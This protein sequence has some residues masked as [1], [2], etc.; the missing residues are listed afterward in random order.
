MKL[1]TL[2]YSGL[3]AILVLSSQSR[4]DIVTF[5]FDTIPNDVA[6]FDIL[7]VDTG[8]TLSLRNARPEFS[9]PEFDNISNWDGANVGLTFDFNSDGFVNMRSIDI[10]FD[11]NVAILGYSISVSTVDWN[12]GSHTVAFGSVTGL[13]T[14][15]G[16]HSLVPPI[17]LLSGEAMSIAE[18]AEFVG[19]YFI[20]SSLSVEYVPEPSAMLLLSMVGG[21]VL[22]SRRKRS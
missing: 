13:S 8:L 9:P 3:I 14:S 11:E 1:R 6:S 2:I 16:D 18:N 5:E 7:D 10:S 21:L 17:D 4:A 19:G 15:L 12:N 22:T 20:I